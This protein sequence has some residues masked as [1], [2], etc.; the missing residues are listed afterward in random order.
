MSGRRDGNGERYGGHLTEQL[1]EDII[2]I[3]SV[4][5]VNEYE[6]Q[7]ACLFRKVAEYDGLYYLICS[8][9]DKHEESNLG[10]YMGFVS[11]KTNAEELSIPTVLKKCVI[12]NRDKL[13]GRVSEA[14]IKTALAFIQGILRYMGGFR[15]MWKRPTYWKMNPRK[16]V[17][18]NKWKCQLEKLARK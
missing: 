3:V 12:F 2:N 16:F 17:K 1:E 13:E 18:E 9:V 11:R 10:T 6:M 15:I 8:T 5:E 4:G 14:G 7:E